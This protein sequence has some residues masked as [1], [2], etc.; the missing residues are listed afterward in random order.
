MSERVRLLKLHP[1]SRDLSDEAIE[2]IAQASEAMKFLPGEVVCRAD[3]PV[4]SI[5]FIV[6]GR[7]R[8]Q[9]MDVHANILTERFLI[10]GTQYGGVAASLAE[11]NPVI[12]HAEDPTELLRVDYSKAWEL[13]RKHPT[14]RRNCAR[15]IAESLKRVITKGKTPVWPRIVT[16]FHQSPAT[17]DVSRNLVERLVDLGESVGVLSDLPMKVDGIQQRLIFADDSDADFELSRRLA[18]A[19][20]R[21]GRVFVDVSTA[22]DLERAARGFATA[23]RV[24]WC[25]TP[26]NWQHSERRLRELLDRAPA[27]RDKVSIVWLLPS[28]EMAPAATELRDLAERDFKVYG[29]ESE[30][31]G[32]HFANQGID[33]LLH[34]L[35]GVQVG[36]A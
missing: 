14:F 19:W 11:P 2:E 9:L 21:T 10:S 32:D 33:R 8:L 24:L 28:G 18:A 35:R 13:S 4:T 25:V 17:R 22:V 12:C 26:D 27:W 29:G 23:E 16:F 31:E 15:L 3:E 5:Y 1:A 34:L 7:L 36:V 30:S 6:H 20:L